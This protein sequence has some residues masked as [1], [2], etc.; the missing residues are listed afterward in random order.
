M[1]VNDLRCWARTYRLPEFRLL[2]QKGREISPAIVLPVRTVQNGIKGRK[3][4]QI[5][6]HSLSNPP[7]SR[8]SPLTHFPFTMVAFTRTFALLAV[9]CAAAATVLP[10]TEATVAGDI[11]TIGLQIDALG[12]SINSFN[13]NS[14]LTH[15]LVRRFTSVPIV[16]G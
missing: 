15:A 13:S 9:V 16:T 2:L 4:I 11:T 5:G 10:N 6:T 8:P 12:N 7:L 1:Y 3:E 14:D